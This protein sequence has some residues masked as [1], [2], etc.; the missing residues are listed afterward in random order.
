MR[1]KIVAAAIAVALAFMLG[2]PSDEP[3]AALQYRASTTVADTLDL[4]EPM[5]FITLY[6]DGGAFG[7]RLLGYSGNSSSDVSDSLVADAGDVR[8]INLRE[9]GKACRYVAVYPASSNEVVVE[10]Y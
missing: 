1:A 10:A 5:G 6:S 7:Y 8:N 2:G 9:Q 4:G 3:T